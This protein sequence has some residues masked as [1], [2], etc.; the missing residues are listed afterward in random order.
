MAWVG[1]YFLVGVPFLV[2]LLSLWPVADEEL[3]KQ[4]DC[5]LGGVLLVMF[6]PIILLS[7]ALQWWRK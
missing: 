4:R 7:T 3:S 6:W 5:V 2:L 1:L